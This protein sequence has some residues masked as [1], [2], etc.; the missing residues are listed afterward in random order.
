MTAPE[1]YPLATKITNIFVQAD[2]E[3]RSSAGITAARPGHRR[4]DA[5]VD[6]EYQVPI[7]TPE[8]MAQIRD[9]LKEVYRRSPAST[10]SR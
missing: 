10:C 1:D 6:L 5:S 4:G 8:T 2:R 7:S 3:R 9:L